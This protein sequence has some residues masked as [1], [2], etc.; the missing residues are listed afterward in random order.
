MLTAAASYGTLQFA[1]GPRPAEIHVRWA[2]EADGPQREAAESRYG[3]SEGALLEGR[4]WSYTIRDLSSSNV[5]ALVRDAAI[6]D[7]HD[8]DRATFRVSPTAPRRPYDTEYPWIPVSLNAVAILGLMIGLVSVSLGL[9]ER[10]LPG[11]TGKWATALGQRARNPSIQPR[12]VLLSV[13]IVMAGCFFAA[14]TMNLRAD[15]RAHLEQINRYLDDDY[16][17]TTGMVGGFHATAMVFARLAGTADRGSIRLLVLLIS[18]ATILVFRSLILSFE[19][20]ASVTRTLQFTFF[21]LLF[22]FW[23]LIYTDV[24]ALMFLLLAVLALTRARVDAAGILVILSMMVRQSYVVW[25]AML[26]L[27]TVAV[28]AT[29]PLV[30]LVRRGASFGVGIGCF[31]LFVIINGGVAVGGQESHPNVAFHTENLLFMLVCFF[32]LFLPLILSKLP[33]IA[34]LH[35]AVIG[36]VVLSSLI[37]F[38]GTFRVDHPWNSPSD[39]YFLRNRLLDAMTS[40]MAAGIV[41]SA[42]VALAA[43]SLCV[44]RLRQ[45][46][47]YLVY[48]FAILSVAPSWLIEQRYY[49]PAFALFMLFRESAS[50][51]VERAILAVNS[52]VALWLHFGVVNAWFFL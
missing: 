15:E 3:L 31:L 33:Q 51:R 44:I 23:F 43:L 13:V 16:S 32:L 47:H 10:G 28:N 9:V 49:L 30:R 22:P 6:E 37:L 5:S 27:W 36:G 26:G 8:I 39:D 42:A 38:F 18:A 20:E 46:I 52:G 4:T 34:R 29:E 2:P 17:T 19:P 21:P 40:S 1:F 41:T 12:L 50:P 14:R 35:P 11:S 48:P 7:T 24:Y 45:P 25:L